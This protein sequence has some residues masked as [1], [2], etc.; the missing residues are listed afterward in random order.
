MPR[1]NPEV[2]YKKLAVE[3]QKHIPGLIEQFKL[4]SFDVAFQLS[5]FLDQSM[6]YDQFGSLNSEDAPYQVFRKRD[7]KQFSK[8]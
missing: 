8:L 7:E 3:W 1:F 4:T 5:N 2:N 6:Q